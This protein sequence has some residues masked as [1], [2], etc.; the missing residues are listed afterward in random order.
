[1]TGDTQTGFTFV[2]RKGGVWD[3][4]L[5]L[6]SARRVDNSDY[7]TLT[8]IGEFSLLLLKPKEKLLTE[9]LRNN[10]LLMAIVW[11]IVQPQ[12]TKSLVKTEDE[13]MDAMD[14]PTIKK[15]K[16]AFW[17]SLA[18]FFQDEQ[19]VLLKMQET[20]Q[21]SLTE[22]SRLVTERT[23]QMRERV[24]TQAMAGVDRVLLGKDQSETIA[25]SG[26]S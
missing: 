15:A 5:T 20:Y 9:L 23:D 12:L 13:F 18:D 25:G 2:D 6:L 16:E 21:T 22:V 10:G 24:V 17:R 4:S 8:D 11:T 7:K 1:M 26:S 3:V 19:T 14:G